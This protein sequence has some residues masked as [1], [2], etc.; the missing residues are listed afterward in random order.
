MFLILFVES[1]Y[2]CFGVLNNP[3]PIVVLIEQTF[4]VEALDL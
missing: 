2:E 1:V 3:K 4:R